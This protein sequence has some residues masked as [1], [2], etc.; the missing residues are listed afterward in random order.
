MTKRFDPINP[1]CRHMLHGGDYNPDQWIRTP[2]IWD[3]DMRLMNLAGCNAM[4]VGIFAWSA[5]EPEEGRFEFGWLDTIMDKL[6]DNGAYAVLATPSGAKPAWMSRAYPEIRR[7][8]AD[9]VRQPHSRRHNHCRTSPVYRE[10]TGGRS[11]RAPAST[12]VRRG[13][14]GAV[15]G[16][17]FASVNCGVNRRATQWS[18]QSER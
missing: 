1:G 15:R 9:G 4:S 12:C 6:A 8:N 16:E 7:V 2:Q 18:R 11:V 10:K 3:E 13:D 17:G 5:L 14:V